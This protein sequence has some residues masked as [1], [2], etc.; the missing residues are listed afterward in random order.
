MARLT[1]V[2]DQIRRC[3]KWKIVSV[4][5]LNLLHHYQRQALWFGYVELDHPNT[6]LVTTPAFCDNWKPRYLTGS[7][8]DYRNINHLWTWHHT[9]KILH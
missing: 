9:I 5:L 1:A 8:S 4:A 6:G 2:K 3:R 7:F